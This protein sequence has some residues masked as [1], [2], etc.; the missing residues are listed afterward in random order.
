MRFVFP[1]PAKDARSQQAADAEGV[2]R[3][4]SSWLLR[5]T[6]LAGLAGILI[7]ISAIHASPALAQQDP[8]SSLL[9]ALQKPADSNTPLL[10]EATELRY[11]F[12]RDVISAVG[13]VQIYYDNY[14]VEADRVDYDRRNSTLK[15]SGNVRLTEPDGNVLTT[16]SI[17]LSDNL[18]DGFAEAL[19]LDTPQRTRFI[20]DTA[21]REAGNKTTF[22]NG[23]YT[24]Y[25]RPTTPPNKPPL[26]RVRA[27]KIV[28]DQQER[29]IY[30]ED[31]SLEFF[32]KPII[33]LP[34][35]SM[36]D[37]TVRNKSGFL[38]PSAVVGSRVGAGLT[39]PYEVALDPTYDLLLQATPLTKQ[40]VLGQAEWRQRLDTG[41][42]SIFGGAILQ[43][44]PGEFAGS[45]GD[46]RFRGVIGSEG[47]FDINERWNWGWDVSYRSD[48]AFLKDYSFTEFGSANDI[49]RIFLE[50]NTEQNRFEA[51][52]YA[53]RISQE[54]YVT[55]PPSLNA[56]GFAPVGSQ[57]QDKQPYVHPVVDY[58]YIYG[59]PIA[60]GELSFVGNLTSL[61]RDTTDAINVNTVDRF[62]GVEGT[63]TRTTLEASWR[64]SL[65]DPLGQ[66]F[67]PFAYVKGD[68]F[69]L[70]SADQN[71]TALTGD[72]VVANGMPA[73]GLEYRYPI[74][75]TFEG[76]N[77]VFEPVAQIIVRPDEQRIGQLPNEDAQSI[78]F[79]STTLFEWDKFSGFDR[80]EGGTRANLGVKYKVQLEEGSY[81]SA[82]FGRS[83]QLAG[84]NSYIKPD[85][86]D[87]TGDSGLDSTQSDYV[88]SVYFDTSHGF[89]LGAQARFD[90][91]D[92]GVRRAQV[93]ASGIYGPV[94]G[95]LAYAFLDSQPDLG[96]EDSRE[97][98]LG[99]S[100]L[101]L[102]ENWRLFG[103][104]RYDLV[105]D[106]VV[107]D[108]VGVG[109]D[110]EGFSI[111]FSYSEDRSRNNGEPVDRLF[112]LRVGFRT[113]GDTQV[114]SGVGQ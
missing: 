21:K 96:I 13:D 104:L 42:Y 55:S 79:D 90:G 108:T 28:H 114:S 66:V 73:V 37:P 113:L 15:A 3:P 47:K 98:I 16:Q 32:G 27:A 84:L 89:R 31:A 70:A 111:S 50:G 26:W 110:D 23:L 95:T 64:R 88:S 6:C 78:V 97:E 52:A 105:N 69:F 46:R 10:L 48:R 106:N 68:L 24:V 53:F 101:R 65:I 99:S 109:Y 63:F 59:E 25:T 75:A 60:G 29:T 102:E 5:T 49:S 1:Q 72:A 86:L 36:P 107:Q 71:V 61:T 57:L 30:Y 39:I 41:S 43:A 74:I 45:S 18:R 112:F 40:G 76:G 82:L 80:S 103:A 35:L 85:I 34:Y 2:L 22:E 87:A 67:T 83:Y 19:Q 77:H 100:S 7:G 20:A 44:Q 9:G 94:V 12:D 93:Q 51:N 33:Y 58:S 38:I 11:D 4:A 54:D 17:T 81:V 92:L 91:S 14:A 56:A 8:A 62:R